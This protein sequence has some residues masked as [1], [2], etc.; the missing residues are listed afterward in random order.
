[1]ISYSVSVSLDDLVDG[2]WEVRSSW[3]SSTSP[4]CSSFL[5]IGEEHDGGRTAHYHVRGYSPNQPSHYRRPTLCYIFPTN[6]QST[7]KTNG[8]SSLRLQ[9]P[10]GEKGTCQLVGARKGRRPAGAPRGRWRSTEMIDLLLLEPCCGYLRPDEFLMR[11]WR[12]YMASTW[13]PGA[14]SRCVWTGT[15]PAAAARLAAGNYRAY[16][17]TCRRS[18]CRR[19][20]R[21]LRRRQPW[22]SVSVCSRGARQTALR[23]CGAGAPVF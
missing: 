19:R 11:P 4:T 17:R 13:L 2:N 6:M 18:A 5:W 10:R 20:D 8:G 22:L 21:R 23:S 15:V 1:M 9:G 3:Q 12:G 16:G 14:A 7:R